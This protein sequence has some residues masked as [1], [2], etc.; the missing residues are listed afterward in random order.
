MKI[1]LGFVLVL[2]VLSWIW[3]GGLSAE[4]I[5]SVDEHQRDEDSNGCSHF[6]QVR[7]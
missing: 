1:L 5:P 4:G 3:S 7:R 2:A 6:C